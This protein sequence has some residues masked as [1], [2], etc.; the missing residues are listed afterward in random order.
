MIFT[1]AHNAET[2]QRIV[3]AVEQ[4]KKE[5]PSDTVSFNLATGNVGVMAAA[6]D[7]I[8]ETE[9]PILFWVYLGIGICVVLSFRSV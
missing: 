5:N 4:Y 6:N 3:D 7:V 1:K 2:I 9:R 8:E